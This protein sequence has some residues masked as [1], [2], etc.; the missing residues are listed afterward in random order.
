[1]FDAHVN[2][3]GTDISLPVKQKSMQVYDVHGLFPFWATIGLHETNL[4]LCFKTQAQFAL[5]NTPM[6]SITEGNSQPQPT[7][8]G[9]PGSSE[10]YVKHEQNVTGRAWVSVLAVFHC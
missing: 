10:S 3:S 9:M 8:A 1:M 7:T 5:T 2:M 6:A 4:L